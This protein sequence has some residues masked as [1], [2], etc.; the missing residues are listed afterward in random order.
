VRAPRFSSDPKKAHPQPARENP[1]LPFLSTLSDRPTDAAHTHTHNKMSTK[2]KAKPKAQAQSTQAAAAA[3][4][5]PIPVVA[6]AI[7][8]AEVTASPKAATTAVAVEN[9]TAAE[10]KEEEKPVVP[11]A[12]GDSKEK[13]EKKEKEK[14][15][16]VSKQLSEELRAVMQ[17]SEERMLNFRPLACCCATGFVSLDQIQ[18]LGHKPQNKRHVVAALPAFAIPK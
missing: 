3:A 11:V 2:T 18:K 10:G 9:T 13:E 1:K 4:V 6:A 17:E 12:G 16:D 15:P 5:V 7:K 14:R 8:P